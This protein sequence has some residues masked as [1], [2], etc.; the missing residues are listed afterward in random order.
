MCIKEE[1]GKIKFFRYE[2]KLCEVLKNYEVKKFYAL[3][4]EK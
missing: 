4:S 3:G 1:I 2:S